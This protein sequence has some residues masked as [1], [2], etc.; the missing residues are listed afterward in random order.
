MAGSQNAAALILQRA[1]QGTAEYLNSSLEGEGTALPR[2]LTDFNPGI[3][4]TCRSR[5]RE[6]HG[7]W[8]SPSQRRLCG[9]RRAGS[10]QNRPAGLQ[11][12]FSF[13]LFSFSTSLLG[14]KKKKQ[15][16]R[17]RA[18]RVEQGFQVLQS[19][20]TGASL[21]GSLQPLHCPSSASLLHEA[22]KKSVVREQ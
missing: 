8:Q 13:G 18:A 20:N 9:L 11:T 6:A 5:P 1:L 14:F 3:P 12:T 10:R 19:L 21:S 7:C 15:Q 4:L 17:T 22:M 16:T 2:H